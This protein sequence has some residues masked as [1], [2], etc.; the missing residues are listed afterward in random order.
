MARIERETA[1]AELQLVSKEFFGDGYA[2]TLANWG[3]RFQRA[4]PRI[5]ALG[6]DERF[7]RMWEYYLAYCQVGFDIRALDV[8]LYKL[9]RPAN[10]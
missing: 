1:K 6:F 7:K 5:K 9:V 3:L 2:R 8:G 4:W 10:S